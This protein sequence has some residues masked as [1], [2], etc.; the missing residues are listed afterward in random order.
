MARRLLALIAAV[1]M[2]AIAIAI[3][4][5]G[6]DKASGGTGA[7]QLVCATELEA[8]CAA[9]D[10]TSGVEVTV[11]P[12]VVTARRLRT[13]SPEDA[14]VD[15]WLAPGPWG[16]IVDVSRATSAEQLFADA[17]APLARS[18]FVL[19]VWKNKRA[20]LQCNEPVDFGCIGDATITRG[21]RLGVASD[22]QAEGLLA[23]AADTS[24]E[25]GVRSRAHRLL[26][27]LGAQESPTNS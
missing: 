13:A 8:V 5:R 2:I 20:A 22:D 24:A 6:D 12:A 19:A 9:L 21:F 11:E 26:K 3:R 7:L 15:G 14:G 25:L 27:G 4:D 16:E 23:D 1:A 18:P 17:G 10:G